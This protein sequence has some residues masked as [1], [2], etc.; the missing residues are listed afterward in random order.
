MRCTGCIRS[1]CKI[2]I[3]DLGKIKIDPCC[4]TWNKDPPLVNK[5]NRIVKP[6]PALMR[7]APP[8]K[9]IPIEPPVIN[10]SPSSS[11]TA[12][13]FLETESIISDFDDSSSDDTCS[14]AASSCGSGGSID[15]SN[16]GGEVVEGEGD[17][18][19]GCHDNKHTSGHNANLNNHNASNTI[20]SHTNVGGVGGS[21]VPS[22][23]CHLGQSH[24][25]L[26]HSSLPKKHQHQHTG[27][28]SSP[29][30]TPNPSSPALKV[31][32][33]DC[34]ELEKPSFYMRSL[35]S[36]LTGFSTQKGQRM[37]LDCI[38]AS[39]NI[40]Y[41]PLSEQFVTQQ[42][43]PSCGTA[44]IAMVLN[45]LQI[46]PQKVWQ[47]PWRWYNENQ[48]ESCLTNQS[49]ANKGMTLEE[50]AYIAECN[51]LHPSVFYAD[52][53][54]SLNAFREALRQNVANPTGKNVDTRVVTNF[55]RQRLGQTGSG[56]YS[57]IGAYHEGKDK[58]LILDVARFKYPPYWVSVTEL[59]EAMKDVDSESGRPRGFL[60]LQKA[61]ECTESCYVE[62]S[63]PLL[64][65][66]QDAM[67]DIRQQPH[68]KCVARAYSHRL[69]RSLIRQ[70]EKLDTLFNFIRT[71]PVY[72]Q[73]YDDNLHESL[74][75]SHYS[76]R[77]ELWSLFL[78]ALSKR[79]LPEAIQNIQ[80]DI[81][82]SN[83][84][85]SMSVLCGGKQSGIVLA[86]DG[87]HKDCVH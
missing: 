29:G 21:K 68:S 48:L 4:K 34:G 45:S 52:D 3:E 12:A 66:V 67:E 58:V 62:L 37:L 2:A 74:W 73:V 1:G 31:V 50:V 55:S 41:F 33:D 36:N 11:S 63:T 61:H 87:N 17:G 79:H 51:G 7:E 32:I 38:Q 20:F 78:I 40:P 30:L 23:C 24:R 46:D 15:N 69:R 25:H 14:T 57:P 5:I 18:N 60:V 10:P 42:S 83:E 28:G 84:L 26:S 27:I 59:W 77:K 43:P 80:S 56:H 86:C 9:L 65:N 54:L 64:P 22:V 76:L 19:H 44:T 85:L 71:T 35:P 8:L 16:G 82:A 49:E 13:H 81:V 70:P 47:H 39:P 75:R 72:D 6:T 53:A